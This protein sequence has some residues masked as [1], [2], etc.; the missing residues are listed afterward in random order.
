MKLPHNFLA[1]RKIGL[2]ICSFFLISGIV[3]GKEPGTILVKA[4]FNYPPFEFKNE[5]GDPD[6]FTV[7]IIKAISDEMGRKI[8]I[9]TGT[10][11]D[12]RLELEKGE[13]DALSGMY[14]TKER[15]RIIDFTIPHFIASYAVFVRKDSAIKSIEDLKN[16]KILVQNGDLG[17]D[18]VLENKIGKEI[19]PMKDWG[20][21]LH[22][23][24][25]GKGDAALVSRL[26][27]KEQIV[28]RRIRNLKVV[29]APIIQRKYCIAVK[30]GNSSLLAELNEGLSIIKTTGKYDK[31]YAK[32]FGVYETTPIT[33]IDALKYVVWVILPIVGLT[34]IGFVW[35][36]MLKKQVNKKTQELK[37]E[38]LVRQ[39]LERE[40]VKLNEK[41]HE[42]NKELE[43]IIFVSSHDL[44]SPLVNVQGFSRELDGSI[45][46]L[47]AILETLDLSQTV[48]D[49]LDE[50]M[51][52]N[53]SEAIHFIY[54]GIAK[55]DAL[56]SALLKFSRS[57]RASLAIEPLNLNSIIKEIVRSFEF[58]IKE[59]GVKVNITDMPDC[60]AD[61]T[62]VN[63][64]FSNLIE[65]ALKFLDPSRPG[66]I[67]LGG[68]PSEKNTVYYVKDNGIGIAK[69]HQSKIFEIF[70]R[71][72][73]K[74]GTGQGLGMTIV[75]KVLSRM[76]GKVWVESEED[77]G[78]TFFFSLPEVKEKK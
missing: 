35:S 18:Y 11:D 12:I 40:R 31:I 52:E 76:K 72:N 54:T 43:Q 29:G 58:Q 49:E 13:I 6:G 53:I 22:N 1:W 42:K 3:H 56:L 73:P 14:K 17:H 62:Q 77:K 16:K 24:S 19:L 66:E 39:R 64:V 8:I 37:D 69:D 32:W 74:A 28:K 51:N 20:T 15:D 63:H 55:M 7:E 26:Q 65:N 30:K 23:L 48:K 34:F 5:K 27:G 60:I 70:Y 68:Y 47:A 2:V 21:I 57:G 38:L 41:L 78:S 45:K 44:R 67:E 36:W 71:L 46:D 59:K 61:K 4:D 25:E 9:K 50:I 10:W 33:F 75:R